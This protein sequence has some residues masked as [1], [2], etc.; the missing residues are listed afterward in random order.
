M[1]GHITCLQ[2]QV[3][4][5]D[6]PDGKAT[7]KLVKVRPSIP[8]SI[9]AHRKMENLVHVVLRIPALYPSIDG[10]MRSFLQPIAEVD[11][12]TL[13]ALLRTEINFCITGVDHEVPGRNSCY[14]LRHWCESL[15]FRSMYLLTY[16]YSHL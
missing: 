9:P 11:G 8:Q 15:S 7:N 2:G 4:C 3:F 5:L 10:C 1:I 13:F 16:S 14:W 6:A 12:K